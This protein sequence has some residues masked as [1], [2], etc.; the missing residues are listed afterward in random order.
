MDM[1]KSMRI[2]SIAAFLLAGVFALGCDNIS[3]EEILP[4]QN[5]KFVTLTTNV[6]IDNV[7]TKAVS[8]N[9][10]KTFE[11]DDQMAVFI[12][13]VKYVS[14]ALKEADITNS[15]KSAKFT[16][17]DVNNPQAGQNVT[18]IYPA[19]AA[20]SDGT[21]NY[22]ALETQNGLRP[23][24]SNPVDFCQFTGTL[25]ANAQLPS[26]AKLSNP[27][28]LVK[29]TIKNEDGT[30][31]I[32]NTI[33]RLTVS[34]GTNTYT[35]N[36]EAAAGPIWVA[37]RPVSNSNLSFT[38]LAGTDAYSKNVASE[39]L[40]AS[41]LYP[42]ILKMIFDPLH[43]P[44]T[45]EAKTAGATVTFTPNPHQAYDANS[46]E[47]STDGGKTWLDCA[48]GASVTLTNVGDKVAFH[49][50]RTAYASNTSE[51]YCSRFTSSEDCYFY[52]NVMSLVNTTSFAESKT[53]TSNYAFCGLFRQA[54]SN[55]KL[56]SLASKALVLPAE[57]L[58]TNCYTSMFQNCTGLTVAPAL[59]AETLSNYCYA[60]MFRNSGLIAAP[61]LP[62]TTLKTSCYQE[63][64][65]HCESLTTPPA[66]PNA[67]V[68]L[69][70]YCCTAMFQDCSL[71]AT[72]PVLSATRVYNSSYKQMFS[73]C[74]SLTTAPDLPA[75]AVDLEGYM[76]MFSECSQLTSINVFCAESLGKNCCKQMFEGCTNLTSAPASLPA[77]QLSEACYSFMF[78]GCT[79]LTTAPLLPARDLENYC[80][81]SMFKGCT[82]LASVTCLATSAQAYSTV[83]WLSGVASPGSFTT[84][85]ILNWAS[86]GSGIPIGWTR[87]G[88]SASVFTVNDSGKKV[89]F[90]S[91]NLQY[92]PSTK[93][94]RFAENAWDY[95]GGSSDGT[96][97]VGD[98]KCDNTKTS[99]VY[100]GW[101]D[102]FVW[103]AFNKNN[104]PVSTS[105]G[106]NYSWG[107]GIPYINPEWSTLSKDEWNYLLNNPSRAHRYQKGKVRI[108][109]NTYVNGLILFPDDWSSSVTDENKP[110]A[111]FDREVNFLG[112]Q[113]YG[114]VFLPV[115]GGCR[116]SSGTGIT[117]SYLHGNMYWSSDQNDPARA[118]FMSFSL[119]EVSA[120]WNINTYYG[121][122]VRLV[123][124]VLP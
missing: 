70:S 117:V 6:S 105:T 52:G 103:G 67:G 83:D 2:F 44:L 101:I 29:F 116:S 56:K 68:T 85:P 86:G 17:K 41:S 8:E 53:L 91:G 59:P 45:F 22:S 28:T 16:I 121:C 55:D 13:N 37:M 119:D 124:V 113:S 95:V 92:Q 62:A 90:A 88:C 30:S 11:V 63:M 26:S 3:E 89:V 48:T 98:V 108:N 112:A 39:T 21:V 109:D 64:F 111:D 51:S 40:E 69:A 102:L 100:T 75:T 107:T 71:L 66:M 123:K 43:T 14:E 104:N 5:E 84:P 31:D 9:G 49:G 94:W 76:Q 82:K 80:Y 118:W 33:T 122:A 23:S 24:L 87:L 12:N 50:N 46:V 36:R 54:S 61:A 120:D 106:T 97:Y 20:N 15:G 47:Y 110:N 25:T 27:L 35:V 78:S 58:T 38:A 73:G 74:S 115:T 99:S 42:V 18:Y 4:Q 1:K 93:A 34:D 65:Y 77:R 114:P 81:H 10:V 7:A 96:V 79:R 32:T 72:A 57:T 60:A 19:S